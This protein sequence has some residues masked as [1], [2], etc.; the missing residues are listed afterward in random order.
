MKFCVLK[1]IKGV[2]LGPRVLK[3]LNFRAPFIWG[4][5]QH[6]WLMPKYNHYCETKLVFIKTILK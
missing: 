1:T 6:L 5:K 4:Y 3:M 2:T